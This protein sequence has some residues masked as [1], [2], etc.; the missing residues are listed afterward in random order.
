MSRADK[1]A[2][3][4]S[5][6]AVQDLYREATKGMENA[7]PVVVVQT[8]AQLPFDA[9]DNAEGVMFKGTVYLVADGLVGPANV[10]NVIAHEVIGHYGLRGFFGKGLGIWW[11]NVH[12]MLDNQQRF[13]FFLD[14]K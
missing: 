11:R 12:A 14:G 3:G 5:T 4:L 13:G 2:T 7:P 9:P 10:R 1:P 6:G 8:P